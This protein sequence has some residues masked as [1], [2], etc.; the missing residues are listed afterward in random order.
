[1]YKPWRTQWKRW[2]QTLKGNGRDIV[3]EALKEIKNIMV[4]LTPQM[5]E[6]TIDTVWKCI[7][8]PT[9]LTLRPASEET[10]RVLEE[11]MPPEDITPG[12]IV[13]EQAEQKGPLTE[14]QR[15]LLADLFDNLEVVHEVSA[16]TCSIMARL[17][18]SLNPSQL[19]LVLWASI[20]LL[21][22]LDALGGLF[23]EPKTG[24]EQRELLDDIRQRVR[25]TMMADPT[26]KLLAKEQPNSPTW[27]LEATF[28]YKILKKFC[29]GCMQ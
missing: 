26:L 7:K 16:Q 2:R 14:E 12:K 4:N 18:R 23:D 25:L 19:E 15:C 27:I 10:E 13:S 8:D 20:R 21:V 28:T 1:M 22:Q 5:S 3:R 29:R 17:S 11:M 6:D 9:C 24:Q